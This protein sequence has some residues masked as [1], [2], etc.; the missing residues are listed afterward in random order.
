MKH[1]LKFCK[2]FS[3]SFVD[4]ITVEL[5]YWPW[6]RLYHGCITTSIVDWD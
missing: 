5:P 3:L 1:V 6:V 2:F 4:W